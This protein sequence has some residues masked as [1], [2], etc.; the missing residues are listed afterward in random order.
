VNFL[1]TLDGSG[2]STAQLYAP[3]LPPGF[4]GLKLYYSYF[5][6]GPFDFAS[7]AVVVEIVP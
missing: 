2:E 1:G 3:P 5:L 6:S 7:N 4:I